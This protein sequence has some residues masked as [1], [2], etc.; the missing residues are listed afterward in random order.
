MGAKA[1]QADAVARLVHE[2]VASVDALTPEAMRAVLP[3]LR[4]AREELRADLRDWLQAAPGNGDRFTAH[5]NRVALRYLEG[6]LERAKE[7]QPAMARGLADGRKA[8]GPVAVK[9]LETE[10]SRLSSVFDGTPSMPRIDIAA[11]MARS[12]SALWRRH[13][14]SAARYAGGVGDDIRKQFA[15]GV[16]KGESM[17]Q[18]VT[19]LRRLGD[20]GAKK[21]GIDPGDDAAGIA[22]GLFRRHKW[23]AERLVRTEMMYAYNT[24]HD[25]ATREADEQIPAGEERYLRKWDATADNRL[26]PLCRELDGTVATI[27]GPFAGGIQ[28]PPRHP[29]CRCLALAWM[30]SWG[31]ITGP[32]PKGWG[33][34][35]KAKPD[36]KP[37]AAEKKAA[38]EA[39]VKK[40]KPEAKPEV[41]A[42]PTK[43]PKA[44]PPPKPSK[45]AVP[46]L[47]PVAKLDAPGREVMAALAKGDLG[48]ASLA[49]DRH[50]ATR[51][52]VRQEVPNTGH[53]AVEDASVKTHAGH[54]VTPR[55]VRDWSGNITLS[56]NVVGEIKRFGAAVG[57]HGAADLAS[58]LETQLSEVD[59]RRARLKT[60]SKR[61]REQ[62]DQLAAL[63]AKRDEVSARILELKKPL[64]DSEG[65][66]TLVHEVLH[67]F[68]PLDPNAYRGHGAQIEEV[69]TEVMAR[70]IGRDVFGVSMTKH[71][72][73]SYAHDIHGVV[74]AI[75]EAAGVA[76]E[77]AYEHLQRASER[78]KSRRTRMIGLPGE[79]A[80]AFAED[81]A[82][83]SGAGYAKVR[84]ALE[85][86]LNLAAQRTAA[87]YAH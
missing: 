66:K 48:G 16:A 25:E 60:L 58:A 37:K 64:G 12:E 80:S 1:A 9:N 62:E 28:R 73:G 10:I 63:T 53:V 65:V 43:Q 22:D 83:E 31:G 7:L 45:Y 86:H 14:S 78:F 41:K 13:A 69:T 54:E 79:V 38:S 47:A 42:K 87:A 84:D 34:E 32:L 59:S 11:V 81:L 77:K 20:P 55:G 67:G 30:A 49:I 6:A 5:D 18:L 50:L 21:R 61:T 35:R 76:P 17:E 40:P 23:W 72:Q 52:L 15:I 19:R 29:C 68:S 39:K 57:E 33:E 82:A 2:S 36:K 74:D 8:T 51:G 44:A 85:R 75:S 26:C 71:N 4:A 70:V 24:Q 56:S 27:D 46:D 3:A